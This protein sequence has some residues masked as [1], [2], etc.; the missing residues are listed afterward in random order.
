MHIV[1]NDGNSEC[2]NIEEFEKILL[3]CFKYENEIWCSIHSDKEFPCLSIL[4][5]KIGAS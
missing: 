5:G 1:S 3:G 4:T 2:N